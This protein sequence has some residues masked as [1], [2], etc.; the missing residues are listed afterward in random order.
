MTIIIDVTRLVRRRKKNITLTGIDRISMAYVDHYR[1]T[2]Q[3]LVR[4]CGRNWILSHS[5]S[6]A[7][8][9]WLDT[10]STRMQ[11]LRILFAG[12]L[13]NIHTKYKPN[14]F[15]F[16]TGHI[17]LR[18]LNYLREIRIKG[19]KLIFF[20]HDLIPLTYPEFSEPG[21][22]SRYQQKMNLV[23]SLADGVITNSE[24]THQEFVRYASQTNQ[25]MSCTTVALLASGIS[26]TPPGHN[27]MKKPYFVM[28]STIEPRKN[29]AFL[30]HIWRSL[31]QRFGEQTPHL[32]VIGRRGWECENVLDLLDRSKLLKN[33]VTEVSQCSDADLI[34]YIHHCQALLFPS[35]IEGYGLPLIE[36]IDLKIPVIVSDISV[37]REIAHVVPDYVDPLDGKR[38][39]ELIMDYANPDSLSR[40][41][42]IARMRDFKAPTWKEHFTTVDSFL[43]ELRRC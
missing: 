25:P 1:N 5:Q 4:W 34:T 22:E 6:K 9:R 13:S 43:T 14:T 40:K 8:F 7:L 12:I 36:A 24:A 29:H 30:L 38:W 19:V 42:Q 32:V 28:L 41:N 17:S 26:Q 2:A 33:T 37:F 10:P 31:V 27:L 3:A 21:E 18:Q 23:L 11:F 16:N 20:I 35:F 39:A 15:L